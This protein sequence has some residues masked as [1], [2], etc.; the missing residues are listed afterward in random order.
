MPLD[1]ATFSLPIATRKGVEH[2][3][4]NVT[5]QETIRIPLGQVATVHIANHQPDSKEKTDVWIGL[6]QGR[7]PVRIRM[8]DRKGGVVEQLAESI[9]FEEAAE[10]SR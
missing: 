9:T 7:L 1:A 3:V 10:G 8:V 2:Y 4:F 5:G 6:E